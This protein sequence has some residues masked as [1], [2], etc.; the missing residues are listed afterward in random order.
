MTPCPTC[1]TMC[2]KVVC[3]VSGKVVPDT[4]QP[5]QLKALSVEELASFMNNYMAL[6]GFEGNNLDFAREIHRAVY[7]GKDV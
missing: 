3:N 1:G 6:H 2:V 4:R 5:A 7:G